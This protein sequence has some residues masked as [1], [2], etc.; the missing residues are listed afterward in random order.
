M[1]NYG[2]LSGQL[3]L[4]KGVHFIC[5]LEH[6]HRVHCSLQEHLI[7][8]LHTADTLGIVIQS[9]SNWFSSPLTNPNS[10][11]G[12]TICIA[13]SAEV[14]IPAWCTTLRVCW[15]RASWNRNKKK[16][17]IQRLRPLR[18][19]HIIFHMWNANFT[20]DLANFTC[21][22]FISHVIQLISHVKR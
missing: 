21:E 12:G 9:G 16:H 4:H 22:T 15:R 5:S 1:Q 7:S 10:D 2:L 14:Q 20:C 19:I 11:G 8:S 13:I 6:L 17:L 3:H 18:K